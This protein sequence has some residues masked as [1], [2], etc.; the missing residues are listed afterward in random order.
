MIAASVAMIADAAAESAA[1]VQFT[2]GNV[3][4]VS[5]T[6]GVRPV[7]KG[8]Q[9]DQGETINTNNGRA[10]LRFTDGAFVSLQPGS[11]FRIDEYKFNGKADGEERGFFSLLKGGLRTITGLIGRSD[12]RKYQ[13]T[14]TVATIGIRG[15]EYTIQYG[16]SVTG[17]V[18]NGEIEVCNGAGCLNVTNGESYYVQ[19]QDVK[20]QITDKG[21]DLPPAPPENPPSSFAQGEETDAGGNPAPG[22]ALT[23]SYV[24]PEIDGAYAW[25][26]DGVLLFPSVSSAEFDADGAL[27]KLDNFAPA[28]PV[29]NGGN[30]GFVAW[31]YFMKDNFGFQETVAYV[32]GTPTPAADWANLKTAVATGTYALTGS[33][34]VIDGGGV[35]IGSLNGASLVADFASGRLSA[36]MDLTVSGASVL[37]TL[38][39]S[40]NTTPA[41]T[42]GGICTT[43][44]SSIQA[45]GSFFGPDAIRAGLA[46]VGDG[47]QWGGAAAFTQTSLK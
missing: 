3:Q 32:V 21:T 15:T 2:V 5:A 25:N 17:T 12:K 22:F 23:G 11:E 39:G 29:N 30:D 31:G 40:A 43:G 47:N 6:G 8:A 4:A 41:F 7:R 45:Y 42:M 33:T 19:N 24:S 26:G 44:C 1:H 9:L 46:Y 36:S 38:T 18:G 16:K 13:V 37:A 28:V 34:P 35:S 27:L 10:Q 14:T 20:P